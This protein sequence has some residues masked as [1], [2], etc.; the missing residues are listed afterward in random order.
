MLIP[1]QFLCWLVL[2]EIHV[3]VIITLSRFLPVKNQTSLFIKINFTEF[4]WTLGEEGLRPVVRWTPPTLW[5]QTRWRRWTRSVSSGRYS[6][7]SLPPHPLRHRPHL[8]TST[9]PEAT[10]PT[11]TDAVALLVSK[12][13][14][15]HISASLLFCLLST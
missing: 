15:L 7:H 3:R 6:V 11:L 13:L 12:C 14:S 10:P 8:L 2:V 4:T 1:N 9:S 5:Q